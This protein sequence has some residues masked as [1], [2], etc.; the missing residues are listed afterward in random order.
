MTLFHKPVGCM[1]VRGVPL[2]LL[3]VGSLVSAGMAW[4]KGSE[5]VFFLKQKPFPYQL[6]PAPHLN[7]EQLRVVPAER[8]NGWIPAAS[9][10]R[11]P[12]RALQTP[13]GVKIASTSYDWQTNFLIKNR[14]V[15]SSQEKLM[16][17]VWMSGSGDPAQGWGDRGTYYAAV[18][19]TDPT[20]P[21][22][23]PTQRGWTR[24]E[25][26]R[27]GWPAAAGLPDG[28]L[29]FVSHTPLRFGRNQGPLDE[30]WSV[31]DLGPAGSLWPYLAS[32]ADGSLHVVYTYSSGA[33]AYQVG[34]RRSTDR[35]QTWS[36]EVFLSGPNAVGGEAP[37]GV[38]A[39][40]YVVETG[41]NTVAVAWYSSDAVYGGIIALR[42]STDNGASWSAP[43]VFRASQTGFSKV[44][45]TGQIPPDTVFFR[46]DTIPALDGFSL[47]VDNTGKWHI[48]AALAPVY[49]SGVGILRGDTVVPI[50]D[51]LNPAGRYTQVGAVYLEQG[52]QPVLM[53]PPGAGKK[54][55]QHWAWSS[56]V[57][58][59]KLGMDDAGK[60]YAV[61]VSDA[62]GDTT[63]GGVAWGH[64]Y[65]TVKQ[66]AQSWTT[67][68]NL[69]PNGIDCSFPTAT[70]GG[71]EG[72][73]VIAYQAGAIPGSFVQGATWE[74]GKEDEIYVLSYALPVGVRQEVA[75]SGVQLRLHPN[76]V[77]TTAY[78]QIAAAEAGLARLELCNALG[79]TV[80]TLYEGWLPAEG[81]LIPV[82]TS[83]L[84]SGVYY[85]KLHV[86]N[87]GST[88]QQMVVVR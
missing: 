45:T 47:L 88:V 50:R 54:A 6:L 18:D 77:A 66:D 35:G 41:G 42:T 4:G 64:L 53:A 80:K 82:H 37:P 10:Q 38:G 23:V 67:P 79:M 28:A 84:S 24:I 56:F 73:A 59:L 49:R 2:L 44:Y 74:A 40:A 15:W 33:N 31:T 5:K 62:E 57:Q 13:P 61:Y 87:G 19:L 22:A 27:T 16:Q 60:L 25:P 69:T 58:W 83:G 48:A 34:Y 11:L 71:P 20:N 70:K 52:G 39:D 51:T 30:Q 46:T 78:A 3:L 63:E 29:A 14:M 8:S 9:L 75:A 68:V 43:Q 32:T 26:V 21:S 81:K 12:A 7:P 76:P 65:L 36:D 1:M 17:L 86:N 85:L 72:Y 55:G